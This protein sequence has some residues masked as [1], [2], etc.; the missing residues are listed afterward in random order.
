MKI[1][2]SNEGGYLVF[3]MELVRDFGSYKSGDYVLWNH[4]FDGH[5]PNRGRPHYDLSASSG[6]CYRTRD[7][8]QKE[9]TELAE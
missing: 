2:T 8:F 7:E 9:Y 6:Y 4:S 3:A 5:S 1:Y